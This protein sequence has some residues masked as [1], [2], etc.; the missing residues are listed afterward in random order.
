[1][2]FR[3][4][5]EKILAGSAQKTPIPGKK[6]IEAGHWAVH[7]QAG[8]EK[9]FKKT[10]TEALPQI[11]VDQTAIRLR[12]RDCVK[13]IFFGA[14]KTRTWNRRPESAPEW[15]VHPHSKITNPRR[16]MSD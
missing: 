13:G 4:G 12:I 7:A 15:P 14:L 10:E 1:V 16:R 2:K 9:F 8:N 6:R 3:R 11:G 5:F